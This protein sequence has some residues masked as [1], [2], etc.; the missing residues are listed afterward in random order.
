MKEMTIKEVATMI[1]TSEGTVRSWI[2]K[3]IDGVPYSSENINYDNFRAKL[4]Q[5]FADFEKR[6]GIEV[7]DIVVVKA[8]RTTKDWM[9]VEDL[10]ELNA[11]DIVTIKNYSLTTTLVFKKYDEEL[12]CFIFA[13]TQ[14][15]TLEYKAYSSAQLDKENIKIER[16][17]HCVL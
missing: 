2:M 13:K 16:T 10:K 1:A 12:D 3:P 11:G 4:T 9:S 17:K 14:G 6:F 7:Q 15:E 5:Y 8:K